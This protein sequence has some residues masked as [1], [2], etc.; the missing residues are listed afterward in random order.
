MYVNLNDLKHISKIISDIIKENRA[1]KLISY[2]IK[3]EMEKL[4]EPV[5]EPLKSI[6][7]DQKI[8]TITRPNHNNVITF[9]PNHNHVVI[10]SCPAY[11]P[12]QLIELF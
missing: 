7:E 10:V 8:V 9:R 11:S 2:D 3:K 1:K 5:I 12:G 4:Y 6:A